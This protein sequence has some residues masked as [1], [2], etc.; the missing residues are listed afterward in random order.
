MQTSQTE[1]GLEE[2][3]FSDLAE[4]LVENFTAHGADRIEKLGHLPPHVPSSSRAKRLHRGCAANLE[5]V[6]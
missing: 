5:V 2:G 1:W 6:P 3:R 4:G